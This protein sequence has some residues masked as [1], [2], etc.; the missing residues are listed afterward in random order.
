M[1]N[2]T[3]YSVSSLIDYIQRSVI[4][5]GIN[6]SNIINNLSYYIDHGISY[7]LKIDFYPNDLWKVYKEVENIDN[8][9]DKTE[10]RSSWRNYHYRYEKRK[11]YSFSDENY[12]IKPENDIEIIDS[13]DK[14]FN[15][16]HLLYLN[17]DNDFYWLSD[18]KTGK[19]IGLIDSKLF[20]NKNH[21]KYNTFKYGHTPL[22]L[23]EKRFL[24]KWQKYK[25][26]ID[27]LSTG[28]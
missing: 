5:Q 14:Y 3:Q 18:K 26:K 15:Q 2:N 9:F 11:A 4:Y 20:N 24:K 22:S 16:S 21:L 6:A 28:V 19:E 17:S 8:K 23:K 12:C 10:A 27:L 13:E 7:G 1:K 25:N